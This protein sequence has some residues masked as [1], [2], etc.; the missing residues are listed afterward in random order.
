MKYR[1]I[2]LS[3]IHLGSRGCSDKKLL[4]F[5]KETE[6]EYLFLV[7]DVIDFWALK[8]LPYWPTS[9]NT[10]IQKILR[11]ARHRTNVIYIPGNH[12]EII[13]DYEGISLG[14]I[15]IFK[16]YIHQ[17]SNGKKIFCLHGDIFDIITQHHK[18]LTII[19]SIGYN[20][21]QYLNKIQNNIRDI[22]KI[23][24]WSFS[25]YIKKNIKEAVNFIG[26]YEQNVVKEAK[27]LKVDAILC[28]HI[29][30][31]EMKQIDGIWY[32]NSGDTVESCS[33]LVET[34][35]GKLQLLSFLNKEIIVTK[36]ITI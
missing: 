23:P 31:A 22:L 17:L 21:L 19:G 35:E 7:G 30:F 20:F 5:L 28:G 27:K 15:K 16:D 9:H 3:D 6:S 36:E 32:L 18:W 29:H 12:D 13:R 11:K 26:D 1:T 14:E 33:A 8:I 34:M 10:V 2:W 25:S 4:H 24:H